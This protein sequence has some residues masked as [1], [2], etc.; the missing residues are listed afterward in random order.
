MMD[1]FK[2]KW[3]KLVSLDLTSQYPNCTYST[4]IAVEILQVIT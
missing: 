2:S 3:Y 1:D 4:K